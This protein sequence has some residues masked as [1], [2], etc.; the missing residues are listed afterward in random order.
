LYS[1]LHLH[2]HSTITGEI[3]AIDSH[4]LVIIMRLHASTI[5]RLVSARI[6]GSRMLSVVLRS[7]LLALVLII[8][9]IVLVGMSLSDMIAADV[10]YSKGIVSDHRN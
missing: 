4:R 2:L 6:T 10:K 5:T 7:A 3:T 9:I 1:Q 8:T